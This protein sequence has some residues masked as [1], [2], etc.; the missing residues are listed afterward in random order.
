MDQ[1]REKRNTVAPVQAMR[2]ERVSREVPAVGMKLAAYYREMTPIASPRVAISGIGVVSPYG[3][4]RD[5]FWRHVSR[6]CS[7]T[8]AITEFDA[9]VFPCA[10][11]A[12]VPS[13]SI[14]DAVMVERA[15]PARG[16]RG[17]R[18]DPR[19]YSKASLIAVIAASEAWQDAG[20]RVGEP[21]CGVLVGSGAGGIAVA[22]RPY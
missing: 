21:G 20:L 4:G 19:R 15:T 12:P 8:R 18:P 7:A 14:D 9:S 17:G 6:G 2:A 5:Q 11:A 13:V 1:R 16:D 10:V 22:E 3:V